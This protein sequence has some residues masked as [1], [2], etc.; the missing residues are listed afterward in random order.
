[1]EEAQ[2]TLEKVFNAVAPLGKGAA[3][4][5][6]G[7]FAASFVT[8]ILTVGAHM[9]GLV[10]HQTAESVVDTASRVFMWSAAPALAA[11]VGTALMEERKNDNPELSLAE[12]PRTLE[13]PRVEVK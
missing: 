5:S 7:T 10:D 13:M 3:L 6:M 9:A 1:M 12:F 2:S 11:L 4:L 8:D